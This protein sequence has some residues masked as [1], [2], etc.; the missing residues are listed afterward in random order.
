MERRLE[1]VDSIIEALNK[2]IL[3]LRTVETK[4]YADPA[5]NE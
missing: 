4:Q 3:L 2:P 5:R 1:G